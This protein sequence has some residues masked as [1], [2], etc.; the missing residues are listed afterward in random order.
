MG[1]VATAIVIRLAS[2]FRRERLAQV[3]GDD[4]RLVVGRLGAEADHLIDRVL[5]RRGSLAAGR[6]RLEAVARGADSLGEPAALL[7][8]R[9]GHRGRLSG[10]RRRSRA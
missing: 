9:G 7:E 8:L 6:L 3:F 5:P 2:S 4:L 10:W 1:L